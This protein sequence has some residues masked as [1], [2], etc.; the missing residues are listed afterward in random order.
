MTRS[1]GSWN[2]RAGG[3]S[4]NVTDVVVVPGTAKS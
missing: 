2:E 1:G 4:G 3:S